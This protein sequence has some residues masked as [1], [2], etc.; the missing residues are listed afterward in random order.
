MLAFNLEVYSQSDRP[1]IEEIVF[2][3]KDK[4]SFDDGDLNDAIA[5]SK[6][7]YFNEIAVK[8][9][10]QKL[11]RFYFDN[12]FFDVQ[13]DSSIQFDKEDNEVTVSFIITENSRFKVDS[14]LVNHISGVNPESVKQLNNLK[15]LKTGDYYNKVL[16]IQYTN[17]IIDALQNSGY[18]NARIKEDSGTVI[19]KNPDSKVKIQIYLEGTDTIYYFGKTISS[20]KKNIYGIRDEDILK[21]IL[22]KE[23]DIYSKAKRLDSERN[24]LKIAIIQSVRIQPDSSDAGTK[25]NFTAN[26]SLNNKHEITPYIKGSNFQNRFY[27]GV[28]A[29][30]TNKY[31]WGGNRT[32]SLEAEELFNSLNINRTE[33]SATIT[34]PHFI[35]E[36]ITLIDKLSAGF[37]NEENFRNYFA[38]N[39]TTLNYF[40]AP[41]TFYNNIYLDLTEE[42]V[43]FKYDTSRVQPLT[44]LNSFFGLTAEHDNTNNKLSPSRGFYHSILGGISGLLP[45]LVI[46]LFNIDVNYSKYLKFFTLNKFYFA[47][48][49]SANSVFAA[50]FKLGDVIEYGG[51]AQ[52]VP[53][54]PIYRFFSGGSS[55]V[56]GW[57]A[58]EN[59]MV[60]DPHNGGNFL[61]EGGFEFRRKLFPSSEGFAKNIGAAVFFD[62][63]NIWENSRDFKSKEIAMAIGFGLRYDIFISPVR[64]DLGFKLFDPR[65]KEGEKWLFE[66]LD[67]IFKT[68]YA[69]NFGIGQAF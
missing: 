46:N 37:S 26:V 14:I 38:G 48:N 65:A 33:I 3:H 20:I 57:N 66:S 49:R 50:N 35:A 21:E 15:T 63:G 31:L 61:L 60:T 67:K 68:K 1:E 23:G 52:V 12:G 62:Y 5:L 28:G 16:L 9:D 22:Y 32:L 34:Q 41:H 69:I 27:L 64:I 25:P 54:Q 4:S 11:K 39:I 7:E 44:L 51:G 24:I 10:M 40:I 30:Y 29:K 19:V 42:V 43:L 17:E 58:Q 8:D 13:V 36:R 6:M 2:E 53:I 55:S 56:R 18:M 47:F 45:E 59:G